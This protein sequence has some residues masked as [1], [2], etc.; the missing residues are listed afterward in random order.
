MFWCLYTKFK[1][2]GKDYGLERYADWKT[3]CVLLC[4]LH[5]T[6][7]KSN[8]ELSKRSPIAS[9]RCMYINIA[10]E[11]S[12]CLMSF[13]PY[14]NKA[15]KLIHVTAY[16]KKWENSFVSILKKKEQ[17]KEWDM[18]LIIIPNWKK[19]QHNIQ[20]FSIF[21]LDYIHKSLLGLVSNSIRELAEI[22]GMSVYTTHEK[23][24]YIQAYFSYFFSLEN[25]NCI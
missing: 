25:W 4:P 11:R 20:L 12:H 10:Y 17:K 3:C 16:M 23:Y 7:H 22:K 18:S 9:Y 21:L 6:V 13:C 2:G 8:F 19:R 5:Q 24:L 1:I 14:L 15:F